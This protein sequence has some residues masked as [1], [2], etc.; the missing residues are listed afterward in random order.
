M[1]RLIFVESDGTRTE[2]DVPAG[3]S[4]MEAARDGNV[5]G[6]VAD[7]GG[8]LACATCHCYFTDDQAASLPAKSD[9]E[10]DMLEF[11]NAE[12]RPGSRLSCQITVR[13]DM[14]GW[15]IEVPDSQ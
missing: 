15:E 1:P 6:I 3:K 7:C 8:A 12:V 4:V 9:T 10:E 14:D 2:V 13:D 5:S 11:A